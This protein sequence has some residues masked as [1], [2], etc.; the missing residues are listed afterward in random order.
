MSELTVK[1]TAWMTRLPGNDAEMPSARS[2]EQECAFFLIYVLTL[3]MNLRNLQLGASVI[4]MITMI[5]IKSESLAIRDLSHLHF[6]DTAKWRS[7][8]P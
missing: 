8:N 6:P 2:R 4:M 7:L 3:P 1:L 5:V